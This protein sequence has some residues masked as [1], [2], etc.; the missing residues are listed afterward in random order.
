[1]SHLNCH[2]QTPVPVSWAQLDP[3]VISLFLCRNSSGHQFHLIYCILLLSDITVLTVSQG[4]KKA[5]VSNIVQSFCCLWLCQFQVLIMAERR[6]LCF[7]WFHGWVIEHE[8]QIIF[9]LGCMSH[10]MTVWVEVSATIQQNAYPKQHTIQRAFPR[11]NVKVHSLYC[12][13]FP[14]GS[15]QHKPWFNPG[16]LFSAYSGHLRRIQ[17]LCLAWGFISKIPSLGKLIVC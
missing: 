16:Q 1:M 3:E 2:F 8:K 14:S 4:Q 17:M 7:S 10:F 12:S 15:Q 6:Y 11:L 13:L 5:P 9:R